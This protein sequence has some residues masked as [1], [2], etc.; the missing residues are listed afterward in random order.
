MMNQKLNEQ[1]HTL[2]QIFESEINLGYESKTLRFFM[3]IIKLS[4]PSSVLNCV[5]AGKNDGSLCL[6]VKSNAQYT[7]YFALYLDV[8]S[9]FS[10]D[11]HDTLISN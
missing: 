6:V 8:S 7:S 4:E 3:S 1:I 11:I 9:S 10:F 2:T 5:F